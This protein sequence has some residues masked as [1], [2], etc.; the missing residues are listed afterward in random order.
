[1][2]YNL[3]TNNIEIPPFFFAS[4]NQRDIGHSPLYCQWFYETECRNPRACIKKGK[5][6]TPPWR[7]LSGKGNGALRGFSVGCYRNRSANKYQHARARSRYTS[8]KL[9]VLR[10]VGEQHE[11]YQRVCITASINNAILTSSIR[12][13]CVDTCMRTCMRFSTQT[14]VTLSIATVYRC[15]YRR[16]WPGKTYFVSIRS[17]LDIYFSE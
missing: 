5:N 11:S 2:K 12:E 15:E 17:I 16:N 10:R 13:L 9:A 14:I 1:M 6:A 8:D 3:Q 7:R 4:S